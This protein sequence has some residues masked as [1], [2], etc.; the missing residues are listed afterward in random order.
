MGKHT[1]DLGDPTTVGVCTTATS[2]V[3][4]ATSDCIGVLHRRG[5]WCLPDVH[6]V[7]DLNIDFFISNHLH[8]CL[9]KESSD[10]THQ[11]VAF[12]I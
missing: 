1:N 3:K 2:C 8:T 4:E 12:P 6:M 11:A 7:V 5:W 9:D 10:D